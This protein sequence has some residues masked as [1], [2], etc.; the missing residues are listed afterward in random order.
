MACFPTSQLSHC[1]LLLLL[2]FALFVPIA[3]ADGIGILGA[4]KWLY[5]P[6]CAHAC[7]RLIA[8]NPILC[9]GDATSSHEHHNKRHSHGGPTPPE[10]FLKDKAFLR[11]QALCMG[12]RCPQDDV[13]LSVL[14]EYWEG[15]LA[16]GTVGDWSLRPVISYSEALMRA[17]QEVDSVGRENIPFAVSGEPLNQTSFISEEDWVPS[18]NGQK[19]FDSGESEHGRNS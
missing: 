11:T 17:Q 7:R 16:T 3:L 2:L 9:E 13:P 4:G 5:R 19:S 10:C 1:S 15:H 12:Q 18:Y 6:T 14:E 8:S